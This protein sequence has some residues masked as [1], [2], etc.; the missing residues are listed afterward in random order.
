MLLI[1]RECLAHREQKMFEVESSYVPHLDPL[2][3]MQRL[4]RKSALFEVPR[5]APSEVSGGRVAVQ[6][7]FGQ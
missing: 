5:S 2:Q 1:R 4:S 6:G 3:D 7:E